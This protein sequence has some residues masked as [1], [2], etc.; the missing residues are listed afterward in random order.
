MVLDYYIRQK[1]SANINMFHF[2]ELP[3]PRLDSGPEYESIAKM[4]AQLVA[5]SDEFDELRKELGIKYGVTD[6]KDRETIRARLDVAVAKL[7]G[8]TKE[9]LQYIL[10]KFPLVD[11]KYKKKVIEEYS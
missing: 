9:E 6:A 1:V 4:T 5:V 10:T 3:I 7:Y 2:L 11:E 8:I